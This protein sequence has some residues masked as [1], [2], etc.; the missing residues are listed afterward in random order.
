M[1]R[2]A[3]KD[4]VPINESVQKEIITIRDE[5]GLSQYTFPWEE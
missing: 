3:R 1:V 4:G 2:L 5:L